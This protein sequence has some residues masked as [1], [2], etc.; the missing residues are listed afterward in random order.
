[1]AQRTGF[2]AT[3]TAQAC[4]RAP[5]ET[6]GALQD[7]RAKRIHPR[8]QASACMARADERCRDHNRYGRRGYVA[9]GY[10]AE[11]LFRSKVVELFEWGVVSAS[12]RLGGASSGDARTVSCQQKWTSDFVGASHARIGISQD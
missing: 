8:A 2:H 12:S 10:V 9:A 11:H 7:N 5:P 4:R 6:P 1:M 3:R